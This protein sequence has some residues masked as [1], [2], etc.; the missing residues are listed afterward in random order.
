[1]AERVLIRSLELYYVR[2]RW[3]LLRVR[4]D[5]GIDG[6][7]EAVLEGNLRA[8]RGAV[9]TLADYLVGQDP[10]AVGRHWARM[11][12]DNFYRG[13]PVLTS[14]I[15]AI[16]IALWDIKGKLL[17]VPVYELLG[18][19]VRDAVPVYCHISGDTTDEL[20][21][22]ATGAIAAGFRML[23][24]G[25]SGP[26]RDYPSALMSTPRSS[27]SIASARRSVLPTSLASTSTAGRR[28]RSA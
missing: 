6:W 4:T 5:A 14:A 27:V 24:T 22:D 28:R 17:G 25:L 19:P 12:T 21:A 13:G 7:S 8:V 23:K 20:I 15:S 18:G 11:Y 2:P 3:Q 16:D 9:E 10:R 26:A 1:M